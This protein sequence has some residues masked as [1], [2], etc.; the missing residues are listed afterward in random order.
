[1]IRDRESGS[2]VQNANSF[3]HNLSSVGEFSSNHPHLSP[4]SS[5]KDQQHFNSSTTA[6]QKDLKKQIENLN[7]QVFEATKR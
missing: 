3:L 2:A 1:M 5:S 7:R 4:M 6:N